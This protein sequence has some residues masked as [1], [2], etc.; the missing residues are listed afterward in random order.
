MAFE[1]PWGNALLHDHDHGTYGRL[2][3]SGI[4]VIYIYIIFELIVP[5]KG[6]DVGEAPKV[7]SELRNS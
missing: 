2:R 6:V 3:E 5:S 7:L 1:W 4:G